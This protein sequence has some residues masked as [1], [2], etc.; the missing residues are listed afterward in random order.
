MSK[1]EI[2]DYCNRLIMYINVSKVKRVLWKVT[3]FEIVALKITSSMRESPTVSQPIPESWLFHFN[4]SLTV[5]NLAKA[6]CKKQGVL[7]SISSCKLII[8]NAYMFERFIC[9][10]GIPLGP[11]LIDE[12][13]RELILFT[14]KAA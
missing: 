2:C 7:Y 6:T 1:V 3:N 4:T 5:V 12:L 14:A 10:S 9:V 13:F 8:H 11:Q